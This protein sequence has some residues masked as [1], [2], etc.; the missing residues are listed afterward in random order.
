MQTVCFPRILQIM[1]C[2]QGKKNQQGHQE[3]LSTG[4][5]TADTNQRSRA[6]DLQTAPENSRALPRGPSSPTV[7]DPR[8]APAT[9][10]LERASSIERR[11]GDEPDGD[12]TGDLF[13]G[14]LV[15]VRS[16]NRAAPRGV[17][18]WRRRIAGEASKQAHECRVPDAFPLFLG[19]C[20]KRVALKYLG[21]KKT[22]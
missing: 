19:G 1:E 2:Y 17:P 9:S 21:Q 12:L 4:Q 13:A 15:P 11:K 16:L 6:S 10:T 20:H 3:P 7:S 8:S 22:Y 14:N 5:T 18:I